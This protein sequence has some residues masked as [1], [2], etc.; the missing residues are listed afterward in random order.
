MMPPATLRPPST[1]LPASM[2]A[3][4]TGSVLPRVVVS[5]LDEAPSGFCVARARVRA[6]VFGP[7]LERLAELR[8]GVVFFA[9]VRPAADLPAARALPL[10]AAF[11]GLAGEALPAD[12]AWLP[13]SR[14]ELRRPGRDRGRLPIT[15]GSSGLMPGTYPPAASAS[16]FPLVGL[17]ERL[18]LDRHEALVALERL[19]AEPLV[20]P[21]RVGGGQEQPR[22]AAHRR[23]LDDRLD[24]RLAEAV[25]AVRIEHV[26]VG[27]PGK[28]GVVGHH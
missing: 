26:H 6:D 8:R 13:P 20:E 27:E 19:E 4:V 21:V 25:P 28:R 23:V 2:T 1:T 3:P 17:G 10:A 12:F 11:A 22:Q 5:C 14:F 15:P 18:C 7:A 24:E 9:V 16:L